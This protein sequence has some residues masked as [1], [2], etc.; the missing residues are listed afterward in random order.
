MTRSGNDSTQS[1]LYEFT[2]D[3]AALHEAIAEYDGLQRSKD[4]QSLVAGHLTEIE[5]SSQRELEEMIKA[6][7]PPRELFLSVHLMMQDAD[8]VFELPAGQR[9]TIFKH[10]FGLLWIDDAKEVLNDRRRTLQAKIAFLEEKNTA[11]STMKHSL[12]SLYATKDRLIQQAIPALNESRQAVMEQPLFAD[13]NLIDTEQIAI[14]W[15][16]VED[17]TI[18]AIDALEVAVQDYREVLLKRAGSREAREKQRSELNQQYTQLVQKKQTIGEEISKQER[19]LAA[20]KDD[21]YETVQKE[22]QQL[23]QQK[24]TLQQYDLSVFATQ[25]VSID[26]LHSARKQ[27]S[28]RINEGKQ[29]ATQQDAKKT[30]RDQAEKQLETLIEQQQHIDTQLQQSQQNLTQQSTFACDKIDGPCPYIDVINKAALR[31]IQEQVARWEQQHQQNKAAIHQQQQ[32][33]KELEEQCVDLEKQKQTVAHKL[34]AVERKQIEKTIADLQTLQNQIDQKTRAVAQHKQRYDQQQQAREALTRLQTQQESL[35]QQVTESKHRLEQLNQEQQQQETTETVSLDI[36]K[37][38]HELVKALAQQAQKLQEV[39]RT[40]QAQQQEK[41]TLSQELNKVKELYQIFAKEL[42]VVVLQDF[43]PQLEEVINAYLA[44]V[45]EYQIRFLS[46]KTVDDAI[47]L[48]VEVHDDLG[49][50]SVTSL[51]GGQRAVLKICWILAVSSLFRSKLLFLDETI[52]SL[53]PDAV[54]RVAEMIHTFVRAHA[55]KFYVVTHAERI[56]EMTVRDRVVELERGS[57][58]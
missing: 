57:K 42:L 53:D 41:F 39:V 49:V 21:A 58:T 14:Q 32:K 52:T 9:V 20:D 10:L 12:Q 37:T 28:D 30:M 43:L 19:L 26:S 48:D 54:S 34:K 17:K 16:Q 46:P 38:Y 6:L 8:H 35:E 7:L 27:I 56:Q 11:E 22:I 25:W 24:S 4:C 15:F 5:S 1:R 47:E 50:R 29:L 13:S 55:M 51:S 40:Y 18:D 45:V 23:E 2:G 31:T 3:E 33:L 44:Q 36:V